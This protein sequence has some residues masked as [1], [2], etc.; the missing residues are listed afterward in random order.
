[1]EG[2]LNK[3]KIEAKPIKMLASAKDARLAYY[4]EEQKD[5]PD[6]K[7]LRI[8]MRKWRYFSLQ[9]V[10]SK[11]TID[12][13]LNAFYNSPAESIEQA[14]L[15]QKVCRILE[16][17]KDENEYEWNQLAMIEEFNLQKKIIESLL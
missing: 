17:S 8:I 16:Q 2:F 12:E 13:L 15:L 7:T 6:D 3:F 5:C 1:M 9:D 11:N 14:L 4:L 10:E